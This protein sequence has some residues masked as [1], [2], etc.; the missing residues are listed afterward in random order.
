MEF[1][2]EQLV[3]NEIQIAKFLMESFSLRE[4]EKKTGISRRHLDAHIKNMMKKLKT[5]DTAGLIKLIKE[6]N[7]L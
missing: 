5:N 2:S 3:D 4:I 6:R 1:K 7:Y